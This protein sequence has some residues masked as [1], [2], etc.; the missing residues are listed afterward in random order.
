LRGDTRDT[1][2]GRLLASFRG[3]F[4]RL[5]ADFRPA[6]EKALGLRGGLP[7]NGF[8]VFAF[9]APLRSLA[10]TQDV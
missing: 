6:V 10:E 4:W 5:Y 8:D 3:Y 2:V 1:R 7:E 9:R